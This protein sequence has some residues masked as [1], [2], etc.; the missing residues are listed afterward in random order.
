MM[1]QEPV[2]RPSFQLSDFGNRQKVHEALK[3]CSCRKATY[4]NRPCVFCGSTARRAY[5]Q[6]PKKYTFLGYSVGITAV[7]MLIATLAAGIA[8]GVWGIVVLVLAAVVMLIRIIKIFLSLEEEQL[9]MYWTFHGSG[10]KQ[11]KNYAKI[12]KKGTSCPI[13]SVDSEIQEEFMDAYYRDLNRMEQEVYE[14]KARTGTNRMEWIA[15]L[16]DTEKLSDVYHHS[17]LARLQFDIIMHLSPQDTQITEFNRICACLN[18]LDMDFYRRYQAWHFL[19]EYLLLA[20]YTECAEVKRLF[21]AM[22]SSILFSREYKKPTV[23][24]TRE[25]RLDNLIKICG[26]RVFQKAWPGCE[27]YNSEGKV[28]VPQDRDALIRLSVEIR[29]FSQLYHSQLIASGEWIYLILNLK[30]MEEVQLKDLGADLESQYCYSW[31]KSL[32]QEKRKLL[33]YERPAGYSSMYTLWCN[34]GL[35]KVPVTVF[36]MFLPEEMLFAAQVWN[37]CVWNAYGVC[38]RD[39]EELKIGRLLKFFQQDSEDGR[40]LAECWKQAGGD[41]W[42]LEH[43]SEPDAEDASMEV[44]A[45]RES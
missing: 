20:D 37:H 45:C 1:Y 35:Q 21:D 16:K 3:R 10:K 6:T 44:E 13:R 5:S 14:A 2:Y 36:T 9:E 34:E 11:I 12:R 40:L 19:G 30:G 15:L 43:N 39:M 33:S 26:T 18:A 17:R 23:A 38:Y 41:D 32:D 22:G 7:S 42:F 4:L 24:Y 8:F 27:I 28:E 31:I 29:N 25:E